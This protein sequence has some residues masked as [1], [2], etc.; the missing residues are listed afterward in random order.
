METKIFIKPTKKENCGS[1][2]KGEYQVITIL[3]SDNHIE[4]LNETDIET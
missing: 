1:N 2:H 4:K 3:Q